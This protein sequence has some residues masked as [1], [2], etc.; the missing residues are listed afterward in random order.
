[1]TLSIGLDNLHQTW[2]GHRL[3]VV[4]QSA[5]VHELVLVIAG[6]MWYDII[7]WMGTHWDTIYHHHKHQGA[8]KEESLIHENGNLS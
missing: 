4:A 6:K 3:E 7:K 8:S 2:N 5:N 1:M